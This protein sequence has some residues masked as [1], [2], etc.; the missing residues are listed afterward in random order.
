MPEFRRGPQ[1]TR[2]R[3]RLREQLAMMTL[4][5]EALFACLVQHRYDARI[6]H[7]IAQGPFLD[8]GDAT[9]VFARRRKPGSGGDP[10]IDI[11]QRRH[12]FERNA[13][14]VRKHV[15]DL[16]AQRVRRQCLQERLRV[17]QR[18]RAPLRRVELLA[19]QHFVQHELRHRQRMFDLFGKRFLAELPDIAIGIVLGRQ[20]QEPDRPVVGS[21]RQARVERPAR[22]APP[23]RIA[24]E[25]EDDRVGLPQQLLHMDRRACRA[26]GRNGIRKSELRQCNDIHV[27]FHDQDEAG[28]ANRQTRFEQTVQLAALAK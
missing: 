3:R 7:Q 1:R 27:T 23:G 11:A 24:V 14:P 22:R 28:L 6:H 10:R 19:R 8:A 4:V 16:R 9:S 17:E 20:E 12:F 26:Q 13:E 25:A 18:P 15:H 2:V 5:H 21:M